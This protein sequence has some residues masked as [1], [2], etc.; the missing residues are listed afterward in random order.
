MMI[1]I[2]SIV[3]SCKIY[4]YIILYYIMIYNDIYI[5][6]MIYTVYIVIFSEHVVIF[7]NIGFGNQ[8]EY[9]SQP[10]KQITRIVL[11]VGQT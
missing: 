4:I 7:F 2:G 5:Y 10:N 11:F 3:K 6:I 8:N 1:I 9:N